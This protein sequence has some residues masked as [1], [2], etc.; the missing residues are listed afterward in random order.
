MKTTKKDIIA[1]EGYPFIAS[2]AIGSFL[3]KNKFLKATLLGASAFSVYFFRNPKKNIHYEK[4]MVLSP[5]DGTIV[6]ISNAYERFFFKSEVNK[7]SIFMSVFDVH[8]N[9]APFKGV[10][11]DKIYNKGLFISANKPKAS[12]ENEQCALLF[13]NEDGKKI[14][15]VQ[16]A[17]IIARRIVTYTKPNDKVE[18]GDIIGL[19]RFGSRVD[20]YSENELNLAVHMNQKIKGGDLIGYL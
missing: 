2:F 9:L 12:L 16:I 3:F 20:I 14:V 8:I 17:G 10:C 11:L 6:D 7:I 13:E 15:V 18:A 4:N 5:A 1:K 19:I